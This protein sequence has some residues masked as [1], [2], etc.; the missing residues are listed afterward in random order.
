MAEAAAS[1]TTALDRILADISVLGLDQNLVELETR[2]YTVI[3]GVLSADT[4]ERAR[5]A[6]LAG[7]EFIFAP[8]LN[9][10]VISMA[11]RYDRPAVRVGHAESARGHPRNPG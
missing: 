8:T 10:D 3:E 5:A 1:E 4:I 6:I 2:G 11:H 7:A 9:L